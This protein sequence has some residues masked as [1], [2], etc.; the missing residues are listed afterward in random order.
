MIARPDR[1]RGT[2]ILCNAYAFEWDAL[3][4]R[5]D[6]S[7][8]EFFHAALNCAHRLTS[9]FSFPIIWV[10]DARGALTLLD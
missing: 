10:E 1:P 7:N 8:A 4:A 2:G 6:G 9:I 5:S 3:V